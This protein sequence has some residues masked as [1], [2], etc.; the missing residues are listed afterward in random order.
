MTY[1]ENLQMNHRL[2]ILIAVVFFLP[3]LLITGCNQSATP[4][5]ANTKA[6]AT[7]TPDISVRDSP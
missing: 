5:V 3:I 1:S 4:P 6:P 7:A 2:L